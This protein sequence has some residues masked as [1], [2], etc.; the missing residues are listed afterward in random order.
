MC[1]MFCPTCQADN[2][3]RVGGVGGPRS[4]YL[5]MCGQI[6]YE[7]RYCGTRGWGPGSSPGLIC[8]CEPGDIRVELDGNAWC[9]KR[10]NFINLQ[11]SLAG[12]GP[13]RLD[14]VRDLLAYEKQEPA[15]KGAAEGGG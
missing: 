5:D 6:G 13:T 10:S 7:C 4:F 12:F 9:A 11:E 3:M 2:C 1:A 14:A 8:S 15:E